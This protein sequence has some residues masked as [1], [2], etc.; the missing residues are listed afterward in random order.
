MVE[1]TREDPRIKEYLY[2]NQLMDHLDNDPSVF[3]NGNLVYPKQF[4]IHLPANHIKPC[5]LN[6][7][8]CAGQHFK[9]PLGAWEN[10]AL[11]LLDG[12]AGRIPQHIYG[13]SYTEPLMNPYVMA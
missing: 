10:G 6:C 9:K 11:S 7:E 5:M 4:E 8:Y 1:N 12:I 3:F 2:W 13:G